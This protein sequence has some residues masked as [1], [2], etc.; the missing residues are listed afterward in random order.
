MDPRLCGDLQ[1]L[2]AAHEQQKKLVKTKLKYTDNLLEIKKIKK[3]KR[4]LN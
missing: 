1:S 3:L 4:K 2:R